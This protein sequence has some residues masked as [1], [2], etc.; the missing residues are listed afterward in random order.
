MA[1]HANEDSRGKPGNYTMMQFFEWY[2]EGDG[3]H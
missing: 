2:A 3:V 1:H